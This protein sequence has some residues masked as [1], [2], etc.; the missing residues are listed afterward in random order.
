MQ[1]D[2]KPAGQRLSPSRS[3][4]PQ[5]ATAQSDGGPRSRMA[6]AAAAVQ[7]MPFAALFYWVD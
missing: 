4:Q 5:A 6:R 1:V 3:A 7:E 2:S